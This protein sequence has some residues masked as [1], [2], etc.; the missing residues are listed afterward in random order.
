MNLRPR[1]RDQVSLDLTPLIDAVFL[2]IIFFMVTTTFDR[3]TQLQLELPQATE[4]QQ[5]DKESDEVMVQIDR[6]GHFYVNDEE[7]VQHDLDTLKRAL[8]KAAGDDKSKPIL[9]EADK[10]AP[11]QAALTMM[12]AAGQLGLMRLSFMAEQIKE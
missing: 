3:Q 5:E 1:K 11:F 9:V 12:D 4:Q 7:L 2:L 8:S 6:E 10:Q